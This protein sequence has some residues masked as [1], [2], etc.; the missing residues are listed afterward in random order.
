MSYP[1]QPIGTPPPPRGRGMPP[2]GMPPR[3]RG[4][5][6]RGMPPRGRGGPPRGMPRTRSRGNLGPN[7]QGIQVS[8]TLIQHFNSIII[9]FSWFFFSYFLLRIYLF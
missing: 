9:I 8:F 1:P 3:G 2:R 4:M 6:P 7:N 5:P